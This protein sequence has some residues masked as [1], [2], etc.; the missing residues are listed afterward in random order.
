MLRPLVT[1]LLAALCAPAP[2][3][4]DEGMWPFD[5]FPAARVRA[6]Y[7]FAPSQTF[8]DHLQ[9]S[10]A[11]IA[12]GCSASFVSSQGLVMTN[13]H[14]VVGCIGELSTRRRDY[15]E[16]GFS[17]RRLEDEVACPGFELDRLERIDDVTAD[18]RRATDGRSGRAL[19]DAL[20]AKEAELTGSCGARDD[21][22]CDVVDLYHGGV[23]DL[24]RY[25][26]YT[27]VR[28]AFVPEYGVAQFGGDPDNF[29]F[30]RFAYDLGFVRAY[31][32]GAPAQTPEYLHWSATGSKAGD[33]VFVAGNP[34]STQR[35]LTLAQ[36][37]GL[38]DRV[39]PRQLPYLAEERGLLERYQSEG[40]EQRRETNERLFGLE[41]S[42]KAIAGRER[43]LLDPAFFERKVAE[44]TALRAEFAKRPALARA[45]AAYATI[46]RAQRVADSLANRAHYVAGGPSLATFAWARTLVRL[47]VEREKPSGERLPEFADAALVTLPK[48]LFARVPIY[49]GPSELELGFFAKKMREDLGTDDPF[50]RRVLGTKSP[51][52]WAHDIVARSDLADPAVRKA[53]YEGGRAA[54]DAS[55]DPMIRYVAS[56]DADARA[57]RRRLED[58]VQ[59]PISKA[60]EEIARARFA[61]EGRTVDPDATFTLRLSYGKVAGFT[62]VNG[63][64]V[65][66]YTTIGGLFAR[67][68][69]SVPYALPASWLAARASL[70]PATPLNV[71]TTNDIIGGNS[72]SPLVDTGGA[73]VG[74]IFDGNVFSLGGAFGYD[75]TANRAIAV[76]SRALLAGLRTVYHADRLVREIAP[77][78]S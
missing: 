77:G 63:N 78:P 75:G 48:R 2:A 56:V 54:I 25:R 50:V 64:A 53:L 1:L 22:R 7:G 17:A 72:G 24:Y 67:A 18:V 35:L 19:V 40:A 76:D 60:S 12:G 34:G 47:P 15:V 51:A 4:A 9:A 29:S 27:D 57:L 3:L 70:D 61:L 66:P 13:H 68:T 42:F 20:R 8:L 43:A 11:R 49:A 31:D 62:D 52:A 37:V 45:N 69:G 55:T 14:C 59:A 36:L 10:S 58:E 23:Y 28:L 32:R 73:L 30:P 21:V 74:L 16:R 65:V 5:A 46:A 71:A 6:A 44:E 38:R 39:Y 26:R 41:N 33:L